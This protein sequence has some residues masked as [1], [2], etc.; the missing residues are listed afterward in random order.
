MATIQ[1]IAVLAG[2]SRTTVSRVLNYDESLSV[3]D[4]TK[5]KIFE[6][7]EQLE[8]T[9]YK[10]N[11][12]K[13]NENS[14]GKI[15]V[16]QWLTEKQELEDIYYLA[17]RMSAEKKIIEEGYEIVRLFRNDSIEFFEEFVG[18]VS[19]GEC[20]NENLNLIKANS[21]N[22]VFIGV[23][24]VSN[25]YDSVIIDFEQ[26]VSSVVD[27]FYL[28]G[29][30]RIGFIGGNIKKYQV[31]SIDKDIRLEAFE[32]YT[33][34]KKIYNPSF[35]FEG[36]FDAESGYKLMI[37]AI[38]EL[39]EDLPTSFFL[40]NDAIAVGALR[41]LVENKIEVP[42]QV[43]L[44]GFNDSSITNYLF[45]TLSSVKVYTDI[46]GETAIDLIIE[47]NNTNRKIAKK[48]VVS[49]SI[50]LKGSTK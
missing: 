22:I 18:I 39:K 4:K 20:S 27:Y 42:E 30:E 2:V 28:K 41:A 33:K 31:N 40:A 37:D 15:V 3:S 35:I 21:S 36:R 6:A 25:E 5:K 9:K 38:R 34:N 1:D 43:E 10:K 12:L 16:I 11:K 44:I 50:S 48:I 46:M 17:L 49:T 32:K 26:A 24:M 47:K 13:K 23:D 8:Y 19:I 14:K 29:N 45:P 7:A